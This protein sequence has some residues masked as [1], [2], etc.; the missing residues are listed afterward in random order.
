MT[1][2]HKHLFIHGLAGSGQGFKATFLR[3]LYPELVA[4]DFPGD[5]RERMAQLEALTGTSAGWTIIGSSLGGLMA[6]VFAC[7]HPGQVD[8][9]VLLAP[10]LPFIDLDANPLPPTTIPVTVVHGL[11]DEVVPIEKT[12]EVAQQLFRDLT[13]IRVDATH[14][15][16]T[17]VPGLDWPA[18]LGDRS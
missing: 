12:H 17:V 10:A 16:N 4:P 14:D 15:L 5:V 13:F 1:A 11:R 8:R 18:L 7:T 9:L 6:T 2:N 3:R